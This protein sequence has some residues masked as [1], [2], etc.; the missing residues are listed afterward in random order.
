MLSVRCLDT[1]LPAPQSDKTT[2]R[3]DKLLLFAPWSWRIGWDCSILTPRFASKEEAG[4]EG[5][6]RH[7]VISSVSISIIMLSALMSK[8]LRQ[9]V[10]EDEVRERA[11]QLQWRKYHATGAYLCE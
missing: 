9:R 3:L 2:L 5:R 4:G 11:A 6:A 8:K 10:R 7:S 1:Q